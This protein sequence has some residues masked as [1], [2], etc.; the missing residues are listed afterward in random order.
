MIIL[1]RR[2]EKD[3]G[4]GPTFRRGGGIHIVSLAGGS[5]VPGSVQGLD[6]GKHLKLTMPARFAGSLLV[7]QLGA[8]S[9][10]RPFLASLL[11]YG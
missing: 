4:A 9:L 10:R 7:K 8:N 1:G 11:K 3:P 6:M 2:Y 5:L